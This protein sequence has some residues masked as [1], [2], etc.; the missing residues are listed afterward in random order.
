MDLEMVETLCKFG[1]VFALTPP[2]C[3]NENTNYFWRYY[4]FL[5]FLIYTVGFVEVQRNLLPAYFDFTFI[6]L[7][8]AILLNVNFYLSNFYILVVVMG[9]L[10][11]QWF[12]LVGCLKSIAAPTSSKQLTTL[13]VTLFLFLALLTFHVFLLVYY[14]NFYSFVVF[15]PSNFYRYSHFTYSTCAY[16]ILKMLLVKY[17]HHTNMLSQVVDTFKRGQ[18]IQPLYKIKRGLFTLHKC[19][20]SFNSIFGWTILS[21]IFCGTFK[22]LVHIDIA[23]KQKEAFE[24]M[25]GSFENR[26]NLIPEM[27]FVLITWVKF[28]LFFCHLT[29]ILSF[30]LVSS[31]RY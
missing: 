31:G 23:V 18:S 4:N 12:R 27:G 8:L 26:L 7:V 9:P 19:V 29:D 30:R 21:S 10:R 15:L 16:T 13:R 3:T 28:L 11:S 6:Q 1:R 2:S 20:D 14:F 25:W 22:I 24:D 5:I 17:Q